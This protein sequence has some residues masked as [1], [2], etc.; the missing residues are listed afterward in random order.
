LTVPH[1]LAGAGDRRLEECQAT[2]GDARTER[3]NPVRVAGAGAQ[4]HLARR[5]AGR[6]QDIPLDHLLDVPRFE[7]GEQDAVALAGNVADRGGRLPAQR[8]QPRSLGCID[9]EADDGKPGAQQPMGERLAH[10]ADADQ[11][12]AARIQHASPATPITGG[13]Q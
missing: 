2:P 13:R 8:R 1:L 7:H 3:R 12:N 10:Q 11:S 4:H 5:I 9:V 6:R